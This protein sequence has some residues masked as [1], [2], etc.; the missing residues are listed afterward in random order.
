LAHFFQADLVLVVYSVISIVLSAYTSGGYGRSAVIV[1]IAL[2]FFESLMF[3]TIFVMGTANLGRHTRRGAGI[4]IMGVSGGAL[5]P[6]IQG[7]IA[8]AYSTRISFLVPTFGFIVVL[9]YALFHWIKHGHKV[10]RTPRTVDVHIVPVVGQK[11]ASVII[12]QETVDTIIDIQRKVSHS[13]QIND[14]VNDIPVLSST[15]SAS[16]THKSGEIN[17]AVVLTETPEK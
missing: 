10:R 13:S 2:Y 16:E 12:S 14:T 11:R 15:P 9:A 4:L 5:F 17:Q 3:P 6:P 1:L 8:D 7:A